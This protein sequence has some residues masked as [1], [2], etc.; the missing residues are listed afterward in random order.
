MSIQYILDTDTCV[1]WLRTNTNIRQRVTQVG[2]A[3]LGVSIVTV[4]ELRYGASCSAQ[5][6]ANHQAIDGF[7]SG[8][9]IISIDPAIARQFGDVKAMLRVRGQLLE[10][11]D[12]LIA[13]TALTYHLTLVTNNTH[14]FARI[15]NLDLENWMLPTVR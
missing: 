9:A 14:H 2:P 6:T 5:A 15:A 13:A 11:A 12:L 10:D 8:L 4:A 3:A 7:L 1:A